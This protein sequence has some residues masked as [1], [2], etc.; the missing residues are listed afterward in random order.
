MTMSANLANAKDAERSNN[1][2]VPSQI[3]FG[4]RL[5]KSGWTRDK[6]L[7]ITMIEVCRDNRCP[8]GAQCVSAG[9]A[10]ILFRFQVGARIR[11]VALNTHKGVNKVVIAGTG[12][13]GMPANYVI[14][15]NSLTPTPV[16][17]KKT[18]TQLYTATLIIENAV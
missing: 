7:K 1:A 17:G 11:N 14:R 3:E 12:K 4:V 5:G 8:E 10:Q 16:V 18:Q 2:N 15:L 13:P 6:G 9:N